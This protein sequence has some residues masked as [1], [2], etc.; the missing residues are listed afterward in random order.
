MSENTSSPQ[1]YD[2]VCNSICSMGVVFVHIYM[3]FATS[4]Q[5]WVIISVF[6]LGFIVFSGVGTV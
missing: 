6:G 5:N 2:I 3:A 1:A 4:S